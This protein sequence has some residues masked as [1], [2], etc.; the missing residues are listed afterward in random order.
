MKERDKKECTSVLLPFPSSSLSSFYT[1][2]SN[3]PYHHQ[4]Q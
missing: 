1:F 4:Y 3:F 2:I